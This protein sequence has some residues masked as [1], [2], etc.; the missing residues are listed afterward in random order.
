MALGMMLAN[1]LL[2]FQ[3]WKELQEL[4][5]D[6]TKSLHGRSSLGF[7]FLDETNLTQEVFGHAFL[8]RPDPVAAKIP[9]S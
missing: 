4:G 5:E 3:T 6:A 7:G 1:G 9:K 8:F 2:E